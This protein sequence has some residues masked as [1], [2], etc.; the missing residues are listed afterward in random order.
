MLRRSREC[1]RA[2]ERRR[3]GIEQRWES[4]ARV[5]GRGG[6]RRRS[7]S[8]WSHGCAE[9]DGMENDRELCAGDG[10]AAKSDVTLTRCVT[11]LPPSTGA[12]RCR[13]FPPTHVAVFVHGYVGNTCIFWLPTIQP[14]QSSAPA[15][16]T[17]R[18]LLASELACAVSLPNPRSSDP[19]LRH[20]ATYTQPVGKAWT[21]VLV[22]QLCSVLHHIQRD[23]RM[24]CLMFR[25]ATTSNS[26]KLGLPLLHEITLSTLVVCTSASART[27]TLVSRK[28]LMR[29]GDQN[30][31]QRACR[32]MQPRPISA[33]EHRRRPL[34][35][36][37]PKALGLPLAQE[38]P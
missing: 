26:A 35:R 6:V 17:V 1:R 10:D 21:L 12:A 8:L 33:V 2:R 22:R 11:Y 24:S 19:A 3:A 23:S 9:Q 29:C 15:R 34:R 28:P 16:P 36:L 25:T 18:R 38:L 13:C 37:L 27:L 7:L 30:L 32:I 31:N 20:A 5:H 4:S 14:R